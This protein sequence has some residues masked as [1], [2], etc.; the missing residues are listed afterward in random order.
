MT[1]IDT[2]TG[3]QLEVENPL[4][5]EMYKANDIYKTVEPKAESVA[6]SQPTPVVKAKKVAKK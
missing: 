5:I 3:Y 1:F 6:D 4:L 2:R